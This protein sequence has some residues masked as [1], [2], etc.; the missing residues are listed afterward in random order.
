MSMTRN[1]Q[2]KGNEMSTISTPRTKA[3]ILR[4]ILAM[5]AQV[6]CTMAQENP[7]GTSDQIEL[8]ASALRLA[9][10]T[11]ATVLGD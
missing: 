11:A 9:H 10:S 4:S 7:P 5:V 6:E 1:N 8:V 2:P 3:E